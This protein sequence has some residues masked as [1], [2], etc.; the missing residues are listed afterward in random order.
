M[1]TKENYN[2]LKTQVPQQARQCGSPSLGEGSPGEL[3]AHETKASLQ[4]CQKIETS[5]EG[6][7]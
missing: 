4:T 3:E 2:S 5:G 1:W 7:T 6:T